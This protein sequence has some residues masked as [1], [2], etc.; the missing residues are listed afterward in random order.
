MGVLSTISGIE[1]R[2]GP[3]VSGTGEMRLPEGANSEVKS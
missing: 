3:A 1:H 2:G